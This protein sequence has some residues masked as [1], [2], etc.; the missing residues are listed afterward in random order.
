MS[1]GITSLSAARR[2]A[3][4]KATAKLCGDSMRTWRMVVERTGQP[5]E[6]FLLSALE[7]LLAWMN[8]EA[9]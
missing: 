7:L 1:N 5:G 8:E 3:N 4:S 6:T 9:A 2:R